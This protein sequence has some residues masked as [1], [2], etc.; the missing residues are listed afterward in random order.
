MNLSAEKICNVTLHLGTGD[1]GLG[2]S[3]YAT[4]RIASLAT[5]GEV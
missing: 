1:W 3:P 4:L 5:F 2:T